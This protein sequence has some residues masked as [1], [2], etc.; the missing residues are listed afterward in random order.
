MDY[1][2]IFIYIIRHLGD[3]GRPSEE[4]GVESSTPDRYRYIVYLTNVIS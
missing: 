1:T 4:M 2:Y 3:G